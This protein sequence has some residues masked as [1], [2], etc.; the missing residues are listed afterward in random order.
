MLRDQSGAISV[1]AALSIM[2][3]LAVAAIVIDAGSLYYAR[4]ALQA[5]NDAAAL[6]AVQDP[7]AAAAVATAIFTQNGYSNQTL[8]VTTGT[9]TADESLDANSRFVASGSGV[10]AVQVIASLQQ[11]GYFASLFG[12]SN[13]STVETKAVAVRIPTATFGAGTRLAELNGGVINSVLGAALGS[14][15][16]LSVGDY[17]SLLETNVSALTFFNQLATDIDVT[18][19]YSQL[20]SA[21]VT[22][23]QLVNALAEVTATPGVASGDPSGALVA[24]QSL[25]LQLRSGSALPLSQ[26]VDL[27]SL[28]GRG[29]GN[30]SQGS[31]PA[32]QINLMGLLSSAASA[33][34]TGGVNNLGTALTI[35]VTG[36]SVATRVAVGSKMAQLSSADVGSSIHTAPVRV[37]L[38]VTL[39]N[40][41]LGVTTATVQVPVY[42]EAGSGEATLTDMPCS[43]GGTLADIAATSGAT[44][45][46]FGTV[47]DAALK[48]FSAPVTPVAAP[49][50]SISLLGIPI[51]VNISGTIN[52]AGAGPET[53]SFTQADIDAGTVKSVSGGVT[54]PFAGLGSNVTLSTTILGNPGIL[55]PLLNTELNT[56][57]AA[58]TPVVTNLL[59]QLD[60]P[61]NDALTTLGL[62]LGITDVRVFDASCRTPTLEG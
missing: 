7:D 1:V 16:S 26:V 39:A 31:G 61:T 5:T 51:Q 62:Q 28:A 53:L 57:T 29:I 21:Q 12:L 45:V 4:R 40:V 23:G 34:A 11:Q 37:A 33:S 22:T 2:M 52:S 24:L 18:G 35:P 56:L 43:V 8:S 36:S 25:Q 38:V 41:N 9:Y 15:L 58:L 6:A 54:A 14:S 55:G 47:S 32:Q 60:S 20:A 19:G 27:S 17:Q 30:I 13:L 46:K 10:N 59:D 48:N 50:V 42:L 3:L 49:V 44:T